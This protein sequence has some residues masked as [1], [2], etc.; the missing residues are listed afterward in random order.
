[1]GWKRQF[2]SGLISLLVILFAQ[3][4]EGNNDPEVQ[5]KRLEPA[6]QV[7]GSEEV[8]SLKVA[9]ASITSPK[10]SIVYYE[11]LLQYLEEKLDKPI[12]VI[13]RKT[14]KEVND[15][16][17][18]G[19]VDLAF[20]CTYSYVQGR[21]Q[22]GLEPF[23]VPSVN[24]NTTYQSYIIVPADGQIET[25][26]D[27]R[28][29]R[30]AFSDPDSTTGY[31]YPNWLLNK[32]GETPETFFR[33]TIFT[34]SHDNSIKAVADRVVDGAAIDG[35]VLDYIAEKQPEYAS[36]VRVID[37]SAEFGIPPVVVS[38]WLNQKDRQQIWEILTSMHLN[39]DGMAIL[40]KIR[41]E[42][43]VPQNDHAYDGIRKMAEEVGLNQP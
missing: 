2:V 25:F 3:G 1:M 31:L 16:I 36:R 29:K 6:V 10:E 21:E 27:L 38:P 11:E 37:K 24:G 15:L 22:F 23:L 43:F 32:L 28:D 9:L 39:L 18:A 33:S 34:Y 19:E 42:K 7:R 30:F 8:T 12:K 5:L 13:Q 26:T 35:L 40:E 14:Y 17:A 4:C 20:I 41:V